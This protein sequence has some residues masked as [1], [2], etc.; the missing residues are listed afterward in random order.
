MK[1]LKFTRI[2]QYLKDLQ[3]NP[4]W[5][6]IFVNPFYLARKA[7]WSEILDHSHFLSGDLLDVGC[8][9]MPYKKLFSTNSYVGLEYD[10][11][12]ARSRNVADVYY[13]GCA[14]PFP[15]Q[16][17]DSLLNNQVLEHVFTPDEFIR[18]LAR[19]IKPRGR[20][21]IT[22]PFI[23]D[24]HE[25]PHDFA[26]Y[27]TFGLKALLERNGFRILIQKRLLSDASLL[28]QLFNTYLFKVINAKN[29]LLK[30]IVRLIIF[31]PIS[32]MGL[33]AALIFPRNPDM[34][35]DQFVIAEK[36]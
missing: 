32:L 34:Y 31:A 22:V 24:E 19:V 11:D 26:R 9:T 12:V 21:M 29:P 35:L 28:F 5:L 10:T 15:D 6:G 30:F 2:I 7:L 14:F 33:C 20:L 1:E 4:G 17:F 3:F 23:W 13:D 27:T 18:E 25:Q 8:G 36:V 16:C